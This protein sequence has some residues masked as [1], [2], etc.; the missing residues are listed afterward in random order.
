MSWL[1]YRVE[2]FKNI[3]S[4]CDGGLLRLA[5]LRL[6]DFFEAVVCDEWWPTLWVVLFCGGVDVDRSTCGSRNN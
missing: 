3:V 4:G 5:Y 2:V 1:L 6:I